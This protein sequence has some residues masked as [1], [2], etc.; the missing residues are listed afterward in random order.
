MGDAF[1]YKLVGQ[2]LLP[3]AVLMMFLFLSGP[4]TAWLRRE[5]EWYRV[6]LIELYLTGITATQMLAAGGVGVVAGA[7]LGF[8]F[9]E[10]VFAAVLFAAA[11]YAAPRL[12]L[13]SVRNARRKK[14][15]EQL[16]DGILTISNGV[17]SGLNLAASLRL[18]EENA[19]APLSQEIGYLLR[20]YEYGMP[21]EAAMERAAERVQLPNYRLFFLAMRTGME[22]GGKLAETLKSIAESLR[23]ITRLED[24]VET[25]TAQGKS[26]ARM[27][28]L[29][30]L[31]VLVILYVID[32]DAVGMLF[33]TGFG[34]LLL[35]AVAGLLVIGWVWLRQV[36][37]VDV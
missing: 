9:L 23:E 6:T 2:L 10:S 17:A 33:T 7:M 13:W 36:V 19:P 31:V 32:P 26:S 35:A 5:H 37:S 12:Y 15:S 29:M 14:L 34:R 16:P 11:G 27:M 18:V 25:L 28:S 21:L 8:L 20:E 24:K 3:V 30:P 1:T 4:I 22:R